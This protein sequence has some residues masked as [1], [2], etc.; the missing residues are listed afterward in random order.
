MEEIKKEK[1]NLNTSCSPYLVY[2]TGKQI[3]NDKTDFDIKSGV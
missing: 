2:S 1:K 3:Q